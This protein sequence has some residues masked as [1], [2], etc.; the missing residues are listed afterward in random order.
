MQVCDKV[1]I[2]WYRRKTRLESK[3]IIK[4]WFLSGENLKEL[5]R[6]VAQEPN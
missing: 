6:L 1:K 5:D 3:K 2:L 4:D